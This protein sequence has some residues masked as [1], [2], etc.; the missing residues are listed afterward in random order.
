ML[1]FDG[2]IGV[3]EFRKGVSSSWEWKLY[4]QRPKAGTGVHVSR[5]Q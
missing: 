4:S 1:G 3:L 5:E 2:C